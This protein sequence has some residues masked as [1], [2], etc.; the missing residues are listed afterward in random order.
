MNAAKDESMSDEPVLVVVDVGDDALVCRGTDGRLHR[1][2]NNGQRIVD[3]E[4]EPAVAQVWQGLWMGGTLYLF[5]HLGWAERW[6]LRGHRGGGKS[7]P[8]IWVKLSNEEQSEETVH[9]ER[10]GLAEREDVDLLGSQGATLLHVS[11]GTSPV[12]LWADAEAETTQELV[13]RLREV[14]TAQ[15]VR[16]RSQAKWAK[17]F[18]NPYT[19]VPFPEGDNAVRRDAPVG[20]ARLRGYSG[21]IRWRWRTRTPLLVRSA[22]GAGFPRRPDAD[23]NQTP[24][25]PG[26]SIKGALRSLHETIAGGCLRVLQAQYLPVY[27]DQAV[28]RRGDWRLARV[29]EASN[30]ESPVK[31]EVSH[32]D[33]VWVKAEDLHTR[34]G[35][36]LSTGDEFALDRD[37]AHWVEYRNNE[38]NQSKLRKRWEAP[39]SAVAEPQEG[40]DRWVILLT[41][42]SDGG[43]RSPGHPYYAPL[44]NLSDASTVTVPQSV[45][46]RYARE[47]AGTRDV[48]PSNRGGPP[49]IEV[50]HRGDAFGRRQRV[51]ERLEVGDVVWV[52]VE[53]GAQPEA[54]PRVAQVTRAVLWRHHGETPMGE[55]V[56]DPL[57]PCSDPK[58][59]CPSCQVF[60]SAD[61]SGREA[62]AAAEQ[63]AYRGHVRFGEALAETAELESMAIAPLR[64]PR[65]G[66]GQMYLEHPEDRPR[67]AQSRNEAPAREWGSRADQPTPRRMRGRKHY[68]HGD[69]ER[70]QQPRHRGDDPP[71]EVAQ[72]GSVFRGWLTFDGLSAEQLGSLLAVL[73][74]DRVLEDHRPLGFADPPGPICGRVGGGK[75]LGF[76]TVETIDLELEVDTADSR[77]GDGAEP[78]VDEDALI[79]DFRDSVPE[80]VRETWTDLAAVLHHGHVPEGYISYPR[81]HPWG[82]GGSMPFEPPFDQRELEFWARTR[83]SHLKGDRL[84][85]LPRPRKIDQARSIDRQENDT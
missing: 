84:E 33:A 62:D 70:Q 6:W 29:V 34:L 31:V 3:D 63:S 16:N 76:G 51:G 14:R 35:R 17:T 8:A 36:K 12:W 81:K 77:Y 37:Q 60:G 13:S 64:A 9:A 61:V 65:P 27:R 75:P 30:G 40:H 5:E 19:F 23:G 82:E 21:T 57:L 38:Q 66:A 45:I 39:A 56:P 83:G 54:A 47:A 73:R 80:A 74:P 68:W 52:R 2:P 50:S 24:F 11:Q 43:A 67:K 44:G 25:I 4:V 42:G 55:R 71:V 79:D 78:S 1:V 53:G 18:I 7:D 69:P 20:H 49:K 28:M 10:L 41:D 15:K 85:S 58:N 48:Q 26:S 32:R 59:L 72:K 46:D 22:D